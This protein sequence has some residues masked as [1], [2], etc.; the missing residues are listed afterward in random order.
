[1]A[2]VAS[3]GTP[4]SPILSA[5]AK[6]IGLLA[7][8][9]A[10]IS[11]GLRVLRIGDDVSAITTANYLQTQTSTL[12]STL[13]SGARAGTFLQVASDGLA[14]IRELLDTLDALATTANEPGR[15][16]LQYATLDGQFQSALTEIDATVANTT[17][18]G[19]S[20]LDGNADTGV[21]PYYQIGATSGDSVTL[22]IPDVSTTGLFGG[23]VSIG[24]AAA[25][26]AATT[27]ISTAG[28]TI[29]NAIALVDAYQQRLDLA[30]A[31][32]RSNIGGVNAGISNLLDT[33]IPSETITRDRL[34]H[35]QTIGAA[36]LAQANGLNSGLLNLLAT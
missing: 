10:R 13:V 33:D 32:A 2:S 36:L 28:D 19:V 21:D 23:A 26:T 4:V 25:A 15:T 27:S 20:I 29:D 22:A 1:M 9:N 17:F 18:N 3:L 31:E 34:A 11:G 30:D 35:Q 24:S 8:S 16:P 6:N 7:D 14:K 12:R 5:Y